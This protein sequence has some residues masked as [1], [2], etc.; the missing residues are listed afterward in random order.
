[1]YLL[2]QDPSRTGRGLEDSPTCRPPMVLHHLVRCEWCQRRIFSRP[3][4]FAAGCTMAF[5]Q[6]FLFL[7]PAT[8]VTHTSVCCLFK[9]PWF[10]LDC[11]LLLLL[12]S[13]YKSNHRPISIIHI[14]FPLSSICPVSV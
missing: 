12:V 4:Y 3:E 2:P 5:Q 8:F 6:V 14:L 11:F 13:S 1:M 10:F 9:I 7:P